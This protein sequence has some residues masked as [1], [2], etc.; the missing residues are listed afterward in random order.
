[1]P[2]SSQLDDLARSVAS[3][4]QSDA[5]NIA[6]KIR[7]ELV[8][9]SRVVSQDQFLD[10]HAA[11]WLLPGH[12]ESVRDQHGH[13]NFDK[14]QNDLI[15]SGRIPAGLPP[16]PVL[17]GAMT[18]PGMIQLPSNQ[19]APNI[20]MPPPNLTPQPVPQPPPPMPL[21]AGV[22]PAAG[23]S[24]MPAVPPVPPSPQSMP[25]PPPEGMILPPAVLAAIAKAQQE[26]QNG[27][28]KK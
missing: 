19:A 24:P 7:V 23:V 28:P 17:Q 13:E 25:I 11:N 10:H 18:P 12:Q 15:Q 22:I 9:Q 21:P 8:P 6:G 3:E 5:K 20:P 4:L 16:P 14:I 26:A 27:L 1:M 2:K